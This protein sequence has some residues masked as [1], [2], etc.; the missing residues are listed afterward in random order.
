M[1]NGATKPFLEAVQI[2]AAMAWADGTIGKEEAEQ[3]RRMIDVGP[4]TPDERTF[5]K[6]WLHGR[7]D[8]TVGKLDLPVSARADIFK[9]AVRMATA[10]GRTVKAERDLM[11]RLQ[12]A[13]ELDDATADQVREEVK[14]ESSSTAPAFARLY[15]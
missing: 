12:Q 10:D 3:L 13:L 15:R 14:A 4:L 7:P 2:M 1:S 6:G 5:A 8:E 11:A 9:T